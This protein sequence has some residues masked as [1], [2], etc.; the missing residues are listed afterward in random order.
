[1][2]LYSLLPPIIQSKAVAHVQHP[3]NELDLPQNKKVA[4]AQEQKMKKGIL[5]DANYSLNGNDTIVRYSWVDIYNGF[6]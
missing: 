6:S 2:H 1:M 3:S 4:A 5:T